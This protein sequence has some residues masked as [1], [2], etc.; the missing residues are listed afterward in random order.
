M[1]SWGSWRTAASPRAKLSP[2]SG[3][4]LTSPHSW[5]CRL[6]LKRLNLRTLLTT[7]TMDACLQKFDTSMG[8][9]PTTATS[10]Q[11]QDAATPRR[12]A[13]WDSKREKCNN[14]EL[15]YLKTLSQHSGFC[16]V[17]CKSNTVYLQKV[18]RTIRAMK[19]AVDEHQRMQEQELREEPTPEQEPQQVEVEQPSAKVQP[20]EASPEVAT[21]APD[22]ANSLKHAQSFAE[23]GI[24]ARV[25]DTSNV[26]WSFSA[27][28]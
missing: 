11:S 9:A 19:D 25:L 26:E 2:K 1:S 5:I 20:G 17:D 24:E 27:L 23:F 14:C 4:L 15:I 16:S 3:A 7:T 6:S 8:S 21:T 18:N 12:V 10:A 28:Y 22:A 13:H